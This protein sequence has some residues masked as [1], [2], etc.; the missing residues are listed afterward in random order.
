MQVH[1]YI[2]LTGNRRHRPV[3]THACTDM[4]MDVLVGFVC[5]HVC[6]QSYVSFVYTFCVCI[7]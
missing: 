4:H 1:T 7:C 5:M 2:H 6:M 3:F